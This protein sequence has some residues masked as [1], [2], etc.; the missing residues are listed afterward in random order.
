MSL[1]MV[2]LLLQGWTTDDDDITPSTAS[3]FPGSPSC[4][5]QPAW[6]R[7]VWGVQEKHFMDDETVGMLEHLPA[8]LL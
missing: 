4:D 5:D 7:R 6:W 1:L 8:D 2:L 3:E